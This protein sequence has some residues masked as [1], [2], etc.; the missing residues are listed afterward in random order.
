M[1][2]EGEGSEEE[3]CHLPSYVDHGVLPPLHLKIHEN[4]DTHLCNLEH[5][6]M[7]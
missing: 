6:G 7:K 2:A 3:I 4:I 5:L 1:H